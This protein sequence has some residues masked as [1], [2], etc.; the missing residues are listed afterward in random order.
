[1]FCMIVATTSKLNLS[2]YLFIYN[3]SNR[4]FTDY[5]LIWCHWVRAQ[6]KRMTHHMMQAKYRR[7]RP[8][9]TTTLQLQ[10]DATFHWHQWRVTQWL[11]YSNPASS[12]N[13]SSISK[14]SNKK[15]QTLATWHTA[16]RC[17]GDVSETQIGP[18][19]VYWIV[20]LP[21]STSSRKW[22]PAPLCNTS[23][24][25][26]QILYYCWNNFKLRFATQRKQFTSGGVSTR[27]NWLPVQQ[28]LEIQH[29]QQ[30][31]DASRH[32]YWSW[33]PASPGAAAFGRSSTAGDTVP[34][35]R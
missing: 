15:K 34:Q 18:S 27:P 22:R 21:F 11:T 28:L 6:A 31:E 12:T 20:L 2:I 19:H 17:L 29:S 9:P 23:H 5:E 14:R 13:C 8:G 25:L 7:T 26:M 24:R 30:H 32:L 16:L 3:Y 33:I 10:G 35:T 1:M 4:S